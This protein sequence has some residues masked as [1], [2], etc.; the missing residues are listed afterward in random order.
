MGLSPLQGSSRIRNSKIRS[1]GRE[2]HSNGRLRTQTSALRLQTSDLGLVIPRYPYEANLVT[3]R[4]HLDRIG[5]SLL[6]MLRPQSS[7]R[8]WRF[9]CHSV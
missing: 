5:L 9:N 7:F 6:G 2:S 3:L 1:R 4:T 8:S